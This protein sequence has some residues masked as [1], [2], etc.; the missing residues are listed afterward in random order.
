[1]SDASG[2]PVGS[3]ARAL[4][5][6]DAL[7]EGPAG[8]NALARRI[9]VNPSSASR[10]LATLERGGLVEREPG[11][12][13]RLGLHL[14]ALADR[15]LARLDVRDLARPQLRALVEQTGETA[16]LSV[17]GGDEAVTVDFAA[18][19]SSVVSMARRRP[20][21]H[22]PRDR[23]GQGAAGVQRRRAARSWPPTRT[24]RSPIRA[25]SPP[26]WPRCASSGWAEAEGEREPDLN[27]LAAPVTRPRRRAG[28]DP[29][30]AGPCRALHGR[31]PRR[32]AA[33]AARR[34]R[35][36][37]ARARRLSGAAGRR[38]AYS[39]P[40]A[41]PR[42]KGPNMA[43][44]VLV[45]LATGLEDPERVTVALLVAG[46]AVE[47]GREVAMFL[48]KDAVRLALPGHA[49]GVACDGCPPLERLFEQFS[50]GG[51]ELLV[52]PYC[53][54][55]RKLDAEGFVANARLAGATPMLEW[56]GD[57]A[58]TVFSY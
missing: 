13:Y 14:V 5:L 15:V 40:L 21:E 22:R 8:V 56:L 48:T 7:A 50:Q 38:R 51:G 42:T 16:T 46:A 9:E 28:R 18:G 34:G 35:G 6:L 2:R 39:D 20:P 10:L 12:P 53:A 26:S 30:P 45:N 23:R 24:A 29:R 33:A 58:G 31:A 19:E 27:A 1:M 25:A 49:E 47:R 3:V 52:C 57:E 17:P 37:R 32:G 43:E 4:A 11:G 55:A 41:T 44:K 36:R 54:N